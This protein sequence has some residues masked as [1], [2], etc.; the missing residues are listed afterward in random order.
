[1]ANYRYFPHFH[2]HRD[3]D[4]R[5]PGPG[6]IEDNIARIYD[7]VVPREGAPIRFL[8]IGASHGVFNMAYW[9]QLVLKRRVAADIHHVRELPPYWERLAGPEYDVTKLSS[10]FGR[11][12]FDVVQCMEVLEHCDYRAGVVELMRTAD[13]LAIMT[14]TDESQHMGDIVGGA[15]IANPHQGF[16]EHPSA[17]FLR[18]M[19][20][21]VMINDNQLVAFWLRLGRPDFDCIDPCIPY[22]NHARR[23]PPTAVPDAE[24]RWIPVPVQYPG[25]ASRLPTHDEPADHGIAE[26]PP[27]PVRDQ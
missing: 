13:K 6:V 19:G 12:S 5:E 14:S 21:S 23:I 10:V 16:V 24:G 8:D 18:R 26:L 4:T 9:D 7:L 17:E 22:A 11:R 15:L 3:Q 25:Y 20:W 27:E 2:I 1:M